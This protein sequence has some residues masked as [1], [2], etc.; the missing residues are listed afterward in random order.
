MIK[1]VYD[2][3]IQNRWE[4]ICVNNHQYIY[5]FIVEKIENG[6]LTKERISKLI[7][8][9]PLICDLKLKG[10]I[11]FDINEA[12]TINNELFPG[13]PFKI[14]FSKSDELY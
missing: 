7:D 11:P 3:L 9:S 1:K 8:V 10:E 5:P 2:L 12:M 4:E 13:I 14:V 6:K